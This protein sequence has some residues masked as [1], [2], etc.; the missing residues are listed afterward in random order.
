MILNYA[1][2]GI[3]GI[4]IEG[5]VIFANPAAAKLTGWSA[6]EL[7]SAPTLHSVIHHSHGNG[8]SYPQKDCPLYQPLADGQ[9]RSGEETFW[10]KSGESFPAHFTSSPIIEH[11]RVIGCVV[12][13][14]DVTERKRLEHQLEQANRVSGLGRVAATIAHEFNNVLMGIQPFAEVIRRRSQDEKTLKAADQIT[15]SVVRGK[16]VTQEILRFTQPAEPALQPVVLRDW[17]EHLLPELQSLVGAR[18]EIVLEVPPRAIVVRGDPAQLQQV[19]TN[20]VLNARDAMSGEGAITIAVDDEASE[21]KFSFEPIPAGLALL[22]VHDTGSGM[23]PEVLRNIFE[24]LFTTKRTGTGLGLAV[25]LQII[26]RH[27]GSIRAESR[28][29]E[30]TTFFILLPTMAAQAPVLE[31]EKE[32]AKPRVRRLVLV[33][34]E[35]AVAA[36]LKLLLEAE[37]I[38]THVVERGGEALGAIQEFR[39]DVVILDMSLPDMRGT[40]VYEQIAAQ[41]PALPVLFSSGHGDESSI[42]RYAGSEH[43]AFLR[44]P[45]D[46]DALMSALE[47]IARQSGAVPM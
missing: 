26:R 41:H 20:L 40:E 12:T 18:V 14:E 23:S 30:G 5:R 33:E 9:P 21:G 13:F 24:P 36:G 11:D 2:E 44:K 17:L 46:L 32:Q 39:P 37:G 47:K 45:Y 16:R 29:G 42:D 31:S 3:L 1:A 43:V 6:E 4:D 10:R 7:Q 15:T 38:E 22:T 35:P 8:E 19:L 34:D 27:G 28:P 25:A